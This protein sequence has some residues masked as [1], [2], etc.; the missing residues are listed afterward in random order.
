MKSY[1]DKSLKLSC[2]KLEVALKNG[3]RSDIDANELFMELR[4]LNHF[5]P[6]ENMSHVNVLTFLKQRDYFPNALIA[7]SV[8]LTICHSGICRKKFL[9]TEIAKVLLTVINVTGET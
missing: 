7:Y 1:D 8:L 6:S 4:L 5:L 9:K 2:S 3:E